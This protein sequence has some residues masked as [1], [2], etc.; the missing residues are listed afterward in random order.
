MGLRDSSSMSSASADRAHRVAAWSFAPFHGHHL[1]PR[2]PAVACVVGGVV[3][4]VGALVALGWAL[5]AVVVRNGHPA[6]LAMGQNS[7]VGLTVAGVGL[8]L[9]ASRRRVR[10]GRALGAVV[11]AIGALKTARRVAK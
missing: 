2:L 9:A 1:R 10:L 6:S 3:A 5:D 4:V 11:A 7:A 8:V